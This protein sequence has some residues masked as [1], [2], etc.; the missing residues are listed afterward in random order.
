MT[1]C[2]TE[3]RL[4]DEAATQALAHALAASQ[5]GPAMVH[6]HGDLGAGKSTLARAFLR[7]LGVTGAIPSPTYTLVERYPLR[8]GNNGEA[9]HLDL[10]RLGDAAELDFLGLD[11]LSPQVWL[12]EWPERTGTRL[13][14]VDLRI[15]LAIAGSGRSACVRACSAAGHAWLQK[16]NKTLS[17][18]SKSTP[19]QQQILEKKRG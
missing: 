3:F 14:A 17:G 13:P 8:N 2:K 16:L 1:I 11:D 15:E 4:A 19:D 9:V 12:V 18:D 7:A 6:L 10:Y 5:P